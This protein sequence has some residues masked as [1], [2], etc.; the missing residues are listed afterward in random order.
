MKA[1][2]LRSIRIA[3]IISPEYL[4]WILDVVGQAG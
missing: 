4:D 3:L 2:Y 1:N